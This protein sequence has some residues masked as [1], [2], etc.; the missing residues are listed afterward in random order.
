MF[1]LRMENSKI[2]S[3]TS[4]GANYQSLIVYLISRWEDNLVDNELKFADC[5]EQEVNKED[6]YVHR[7]RTYAQSAYP[8]K[9]IT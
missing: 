7:W 9:Q 3:Y 1:L 5:Q 8:L 2:K 4:S 6:K